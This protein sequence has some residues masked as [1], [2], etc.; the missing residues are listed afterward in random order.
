[1][2]VAIEYEIFNIYLHGMTHD[3]F[4]DLF[5]NFN[6]RSE[7]HSRQDKAKQDFLKII[8]TITHYNNECNKGQHPDGSPKT[9]DTFEIFEG[10]STDRLPTP[11][12]S[13]QVQLTHP[14]F[15]TTLG[16]IENAEFRLYELLEDADCLDLVSNIVSHTEFLRKRALEQKQKLD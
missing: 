16:T 4:A 13:V 5:R 14:F 9:L 10:R 1:M 2:V 3:G 8:E 15:K 11:Y 6:D 12:V 7:L